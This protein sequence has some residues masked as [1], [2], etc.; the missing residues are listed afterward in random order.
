[1]LRWFGVIFLTILIIIYP[2][3]WEK[4]PTQKFGNSTIVHKKDRWT[5]QPW[6]ITYGSIDGKIISGEESAVFPPSIIEAK[7]LSKLSGSEMQQKRVEI[8]QEITKQKQIASR[9]FEGHEKYLELANS[10]RDE[11]VPHGWIK[12]KSGKKVYIPAGGWDWTPEKEK[13]IE[14]KIE[15]ELPQQ[16]VNQHKNYVSAQS[17]IK[18]L[19]EELNNLPNLAEKQA[20]TELKNAAVKKRN[21]A[22]GVWSSLSLL[23][24]IT[25]VISFVRRKN[26]I[27][28]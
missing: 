2:F 27:E 25:I 6:I 3:R 24:L 26:K 23:S 13:I 12:D 22:T 14:Q 7:K 4:G 16:L 11:L 1:M 10:M 20:M 15:A 18:E 17:R 8:E 9:N 21:I 28:A 19:S 5:G